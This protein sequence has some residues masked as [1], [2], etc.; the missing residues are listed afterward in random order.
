MA[1]QQPQIWS[2]PGPWAIQAV[3]VLTAC[4]GVVFAGLVPPSTTP[5][6]VGILLACVLPQLIAGIILFRRG[7]INLA[8]ICGLFGTVITMGAAIT[9]WQQMGAKAITPEVMGAFW[10]ALFVITEV[11]AIGFGRATWL[12]LAG[13]AEVGVAFL[14]LGINQLTGLAI[15]GTIGGWLLIVFSAFCIYASSAI[16]LAEQFGRPILPIGRPVFK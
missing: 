1:Q 10:L 7:D 5:L 12:L 3:A 16:L 9:L 13:I 8:T 2:N 6:L 4:V 11:Y 14:F 15:T